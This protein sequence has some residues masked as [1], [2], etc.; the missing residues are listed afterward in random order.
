MYVDVKMSIWQRIDIIDK[1]NLTKE[2][3]INVLKNK[4]T[5]YLWDLPD[6]QIDLEELTDTEEYLTPEDNGGESTVELYE[7]NGTLIW[8]NSNEENRS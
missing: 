4:G 1:G 6:V 8:E 3:V 7:D 5:S 2:E